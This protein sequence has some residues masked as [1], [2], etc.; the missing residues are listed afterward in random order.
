MVQVQVMD[1]VGV[2]IVNSEAV[3]AIETNAGRT[4]PT[5]TDFKEARERTLAMSFICGMNYNYSG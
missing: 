3:N 4:V 1:K 2:T 5:E